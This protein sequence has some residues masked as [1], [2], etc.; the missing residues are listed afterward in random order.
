MQMV[1]ATVHPCTEVMVLGLASSPIHISLLATTSTKSL[2]LNT[3]NSSSSSTPNLL[4]CTVQ[5]LSAFASEA[6]KAI[7]PAVIVCFHQ[8]SI[9][10]SDGV[11]SSRS[12]LSP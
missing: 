2:T 11:D 5:L 12:P 3:S 7:D 10:P 9:G 1:P 4:L 8:N 6:Q